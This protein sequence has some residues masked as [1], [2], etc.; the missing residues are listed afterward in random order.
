MGSW[1]DLSLS[2]ASKTDA[3]PMGTEVSD[4]IEKITKNNS[5]TGGKNIYIGKEST[6]R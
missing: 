6:S 1:S 4:S 3:D 5:T 2:N